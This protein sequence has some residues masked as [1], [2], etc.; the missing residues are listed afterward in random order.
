MVSFHNLL[1]RSTLDGGRKL[2]FFLKAFLN[3]MAES[4]FSMDLALSVGTMHALLSMMMLR[5]L[6]ASSGQAWT[7]LRNSMPITILKLTTG[8]IEKLNFLNHV[9]SITGMPFVALVMGLADVFITLMMPHS[10]IVLRLRRLTLSFDMK[11][12]GAL[13]SSSA[14]MA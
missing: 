5:K 3:C 2:R 8:M 13:M 9:L 6:V 11:L 1:P 4:F 7:W 12:C 10:C 14:Q